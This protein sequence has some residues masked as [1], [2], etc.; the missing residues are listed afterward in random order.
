V[1]KPDSP[2][3]RERV[4]SDLVWQGFLARLSGKVFWQGFLARFRS[5]AGPCW[6]R[7]RPWGPVR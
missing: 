5:C 3:T 6:S 2:G 4:T 7:T 1:V